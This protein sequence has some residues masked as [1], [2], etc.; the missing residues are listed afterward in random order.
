[1]VLTQFPDVE[2][3]VKIIGLTDAIPND[4][5]VFRKDLPEDIKKTVTE[6]FLKFVATSEGRLAFDKIYG[7]TELKPATDADYQS[8]RDMLSALNK[9]AQ[10]LMAK[11]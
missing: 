5:I 2:Q 8:V 4:P 11:K 6:A 1:L 10:E 3:K 9:N 7:V